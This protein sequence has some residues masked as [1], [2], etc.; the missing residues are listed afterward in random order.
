MNGPWLVEDSDEGTG[1]RSYL[2]VCLAREMLALA[3]SPSFPD[4]PQLSQ[5]WECGQGSQAPVLFLTCSGW[6][7]DSDN[8]VRE[9]PWP[10]DSFLPIP[11]R[12]LSFWSVL[13]LTTNTVLFGSTKSAKSGKG[14]A[15]G[16][17]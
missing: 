10:L 14:S 17:V 1:R 11:Q 9:P 8:E 5:A 7:E 2:L 4:I 12:L 13:H 15:P 3:K 16:K 6:Q